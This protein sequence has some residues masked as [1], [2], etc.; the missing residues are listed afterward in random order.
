MDAGE[1][2][3]PAQLCRVLGQ[4]CRQEEAKKERRPGAGRSPT[5]CAIPATTDAKR[6]AREM[7]KRHDPHHMSVVFSTYHSIEVLHPGA[8]LKFARAGKRLI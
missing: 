3:R 1:Q 6:L 4:R 7:A 8:G 5:S 2:Q